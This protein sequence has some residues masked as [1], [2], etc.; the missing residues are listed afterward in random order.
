MGWALE[1]PRL[2]FQLSVMMSL[3]FAIW[4]AWAPVLAARL[5]GPLQLSGKQAGWVYATLPLACI[6]T[7]LVSG[8]LADRFIGA[9]V[10]LGIA[11]LL[12]AVLMFVAARQTKFWPLFWSMLGFS[13]CYAA[14][15]PLVNS[16]TFA[17]LGEV[18]PREEVGPASAGIFIWAPIAWAVSGY[19]LTGWRLLGGENEGRDCMNLA[20]ILAAVMGVTCFFV[21]P[22][23]PPAAVE[24]VPALQAFFQAFTMLRDLNFS[25]FLVLSLVVAGLM[26]FYFLGPAPFMQGMGVSSRYVPGAMA[27]AQLAQAVATLLLM[28]FLMREIGYRATLV[29]G[30]FA[31]LLLYQAYILGKPRTLIVIAQPLHGIAYVLFIIVGWAYGDALAP[32]GMLASVQALVFAATVGLGLFLFT[33][34]AGATMERFSVDGKFQWEKVWTVAAVITGTSIAALILWIVAID[35]PLAA[36]DPVEQAGIVADPAGPVAQAELLIEPPE[37]LRD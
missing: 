33:L 21:V 20:A 23:T 4:G 18:F 11:H 16:V 22:Y 32:E 13:A 8:P 27:L 5:L 29:V 15:L 30:A 10:L 35:D 12:G 17:Q 6:F 19:I 14:A 28:G 2:F 7:P 25:V 37:S 26:Q 1:H 36:E 3:Q 9:D 31:W 34:V 24:D